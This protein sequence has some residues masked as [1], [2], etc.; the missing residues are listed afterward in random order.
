MRV[1]AA[2]LAV[3]L[4]ATSASA[5][6]VHSTSA[7]GSRTRPTPPVLRARDGRLEIRA[8]RATTPV[9]IDG[10]L[11]DPVWRTAPVASHFV[12]SEPDEGRPARERTDVQVAFDARNLYIAAYC[13]DTDPAGMVL[14][15]VKRDFTPG[16]QDDFEV[17]LD[18]FADRRNGFAFITNEGGAKSDE[19]FSN[20]GR[21][22]NT[23]WDAVW[24]V[25]TRRV[26]DGW[27]VEIAIPFH[28]LRF[29]RARHEVWGVNFGRRIRRLNELDFWAPI[30][31]AYDL[32]RVSLAGDLVG[33]T[34]ADPGR[35]L[36]ITPYVLGSSVRTVGGTAFDGTANAGFD[37]K[38]GVTPALTLDATVRPDFAQVEADEQQ[39]NLTQFSQ[40]FPEKRPFFLENAGLFYVGDAGVNN[41]ITAPTPD[42]DLMLFFSRRIGLSSTGAPIPILGGARLTGWTHGVG[43]GL[44]TAQTGRSG[45]TPGNNYTVLRVRRDL[46]R[47]S[48]VG[49]IFMMR[50]ASGSSQDFN[51]VYGVD[52]N[53]RFF[54]NLDWSSYAIRSAAPGQTRG[55]YAWRT[56]ITRDTDFDDIQTGVMAIG[57]HFRD[58]LGY[59]R[60][61]SDRK[62][63]LNAGIRPRLASLQRHGILEMHPHVTWSYY[64]DLS[65][66]MVARSL[67]TGYTFFFN[68]GGYTEVAFTPQFQALA[69]PFTIHP[70]SP[71]IPAGRYGWDEYQALLNSDPSRALSF[72][73]TVTT[74]GLWS[75]T[76]RTVSAGLTLRASYHFMASLSLQRTA[77]HLHLPETQFVTDLWTLS[78]NYSFTRNM[79]L[80]SLIQYFQDLGQMNMNI[81][82]NFIHHPLSN[83]Y[84]VYNEERVT[85][86]EVLT[87]GRGLILKFTQLM[88]F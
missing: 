33:L 66:R 6:P 14:N 78:T 60:R 55:Q 12:E 80:G 86:P 42:E 53:L 3:V 87:P 47:N 1:P 16:D 50:Q 59:Y 23:S 35:D 56:S 37:L 40:F 15:D 20:E 24:H 48:D 26:A 8:V 57:D 9:V 58:D 18:T 61:T 43:I 81:R 21:D 30:P 67:R 29:N 17:I 71:A 54:G 70:G 4:A 41:R 74:G 25:R 39:V 68:N 64:T 82:F 52:A 34:T 19:Q 84:L 65:G 28:S 51:R 79:F 76:Q 22:I 44:M 77:A 88:S 38:Y 49:A 83:L 69:T 13:H 63:F 10:V 62:F 73:V 85:T 45:R 27:T 72:N 5:V 7:S 75:G 31:R 32:T 2:A 46:F 11:D 36:K